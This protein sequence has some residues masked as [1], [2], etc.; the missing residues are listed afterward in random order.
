MNRDSLDKFLY[1]LSERHLIRERRLADPKASSWTKDPI[2]REYKFTNVL[3][4]HDRTS[5]WVVKNW[6]LPNLD[7]HLEIQALNCA[8]FR[9]FGTI[10]FAEQIGYQNSWRPDFLIE[11]AAKRAASGKK[12]FTG[13]YIITNGGISAPKEQVVVNHY[14]TAFRMKLGKIIEVARTTKSWQAVSNVLS[15]VNGFG[16]FMRKE[17]L[18]D[19][20]E[21]AVLNDCHDKLSWT[22]AGPGAIRGLNRL[23]GRPTDLGMS[24]DKALQE[25]QELLRLVDEN[26]SA[27]PNS[28]PTPG[29]EFGVTDIQFNLCEVDKYLRVELGE[30]RPRSKFK[31]TR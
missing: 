14:L 27:L 12:V 28:F 1:Y 24:Q 30:G 20:M 10:E 15:S 22:P 6:Y 7:Q 9:Y 31:P 18:L 29:I 26:K 5:E 3:R 16:P 19:M 23:H 13:A 17:V 4:K 25:M 2:L 21:T 11:Q 8:I